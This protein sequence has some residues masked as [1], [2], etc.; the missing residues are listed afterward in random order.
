MLYALHIACSTPSVSTNQAVFTTHLRQR[1]VW[2]HKKTKTT[3]AS[4]CASDPLKPNVTHSVI[5]CYSGACCSPSA[6]FKQSVKTI[7]FACYCVFNGIVTEAW[8]TAEPALR[9]ATANFSFNAEFGLPDLMFLVTNPST[10]QSWNATPSL[11]R[12]NCTF[13][14]ASSFS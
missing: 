12:L 9:K 14:T 7:A 5:W 10:W 2:L 13:N 11:N 4:I 3:R 6:E 8:M 1:W